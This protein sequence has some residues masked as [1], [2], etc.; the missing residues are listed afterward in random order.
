MEI[1]KGVQRTFTVSFGASRIGKTVQVSILNAAGTVVSTGFT[2]GSVVELSDGTYGIAITFTAEMTGFV[3]WRNVTDGL[4]AY[5]PILV[6]NDYRAD[7][8]IIRKIETNS[9]RIASN[10][11]T[12]YD[13]DGITPLYVFNL[14]QDGLPNGLTPDERIRQ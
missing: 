3:Q 12:I 5:E 1:I 8:S 4:E 10:Q 6:I 13:D 11:L 7:I 2:A 9:W 14:Q